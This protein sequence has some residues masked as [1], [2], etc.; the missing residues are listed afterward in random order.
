[1]KQLDE[2][3]TFTYLGKD[4]IPSHVYKKIKVHLIYDIKYDTR[5]KA[6][7]IIDGHLTKVPIYGMFWS[8]VVMWT[9][10]DHTPF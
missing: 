6:R 9:T 5:H 8:S 4:G 1:M 7:C 10:Y 2:Y 3:N